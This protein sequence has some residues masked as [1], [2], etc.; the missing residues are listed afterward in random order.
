M[1]V[2]A[3]LDLLVTVD[4]AI[5]HFA[6]AMSRP[7]WIMIPHAPD[8]RWLLGRSDTPWYPSLRLFRHPAPRRW[9]LVIPAVAAELR[10]HL[11]TL[12]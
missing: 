3:Q 1:A 6:G 4:T 12:A 8:W 10:R 11:A 5:G 9:D 2:I 7:A